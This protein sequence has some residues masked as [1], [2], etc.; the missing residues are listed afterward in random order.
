MRLPWLSIPPWCKDDALQILLNTT[1]GKSGYAVYYLNADDKA[2]LK[3]EAK[4]I[5][6][7][8]FR[9]N[10]TTKLY[11]G[12]VLT[13]SFSTVTAMS[14]FDTSVGYGW[15]SR[16]AMDLWFLDYLDQPE[17]FITEIRSFELPSGM[18]PTGWARPGT[19]PLKEL[20]LWKE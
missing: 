17:L 10:G 9:Y 12:I 11:E 6:G 18:A 3:D 8:F 14:G 1:P 13:F 15:D 7:I 20:G 16:L 2:N 4:D 5:A 19:D